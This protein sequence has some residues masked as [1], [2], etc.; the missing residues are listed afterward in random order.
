MALVGT[1][2]EQKI[3]NYL[4]AKGLNDFGVAGLMGNLYAE[5]LLEPKN[6][7]NTYER[8]LGYTDEGYTAAVDNGSYKN[9]VNDCAGYG[10][11]QWTYWSRKKNLLEFARSQSKSIGDLEMQLD[12]LIKELSGSFPAVFKVLKNATSV[13]EA[14]DVVLLK[15][16][17][18][19]NMGTTVQ[20]SRAAYGQ[21]YYTKYASKTQATTLNKVDNTTPAFKMRTTKPEAGNKYYITKAKGGYSNAIQGKPTD[22]DC[23]VLPNCVGYAYGRFNEI[24]GYG[25]CKYLRPVNAERFIECAGGLQV[26]QTPKLGACMVWRKGAT[27][28]GDDGAGHVAIVEKV[29]SS[30]QVITSESAYNS[31]PFYT[32]TRN[33]GTGNWGMGTSYVFLGFIYNPAVSDGTVADGST[34]STGNTS[35]PTADLK[36]KVGDI[37][38][39]TGNLHYVHASALTGITCKPGKV[40]ITAIHK[41]GFHQYHVKA[42]VGGGSTAYGWVNAQDI[43]SARNQIG[44]ESTAKNVRVGDVVNF[45]GTTHYATAY[46]KNG[47]SCSPGKVKVTM[48]AEGATHPYHVRWIPDGGSNAYGWVDAENLKKIENN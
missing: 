25:Y 7:Q 43:S 32:K 3:W 35:V 45:T 10:L 28:S 2:N 48:I 22:A 27:L 34:G 11:A 41:P 37:V 24:G 39:F 36:Y 6:L 26:G 16:E 12:F 47:P 20:N 14:S 8:T 46:A 23:D 13:R 18:P 44:S 30:T 40:L 42:V 31:T 33:N 19:A 29:V 17:K 5:S 15:Y 38:D 21:K 1:T 4:K 9:F